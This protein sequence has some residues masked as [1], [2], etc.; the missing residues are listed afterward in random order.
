MPSTVWNNNYIYL[1]HVHTLMDLFSAFSVFW[2]HVHKNFWPMKMKIFKTTLQVEDILRLFNCSY[3]DGKNNSA[4]TYKSPLVIRCLA[5]CC[6]FVVSFNN[7][8]FSAHYCT[9]AS[10]YN[11]TKYGNMANSVDDLCVKF[12]IQSESNNHKQANVK[13]HPG[14]TRQIS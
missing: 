6:Y 5:N 14:M 3:L 1:V 2:P 7:I 4:L 10:G 9:E 11:C 12:L 13:A 8:Y